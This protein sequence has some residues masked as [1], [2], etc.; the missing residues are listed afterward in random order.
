MDSTRKNHK[1]AF[2]NLSKIYSNPLFILTII[3]V[4]ITAYLLEV[5]MKIGVP[6]W[7]VFNYLNNALYFAGMGKGSVLYLPP[8]IP[9]LT[10]LFFKAGYVSLN[11]IFILDSI[12]FIIG[13]IGL[14]LLL[15]QRFNEIQSLTGSL[16]FI[17]FPVVLAWAVTGGIDIPGVSFSI[18]AIYLTVLGI[19][20]N[21]KYLYFVIPLTMLAFLTRYT[22]GLIILPVLFYSLINIREI[23]KIKKVVIGILLELIVLVSG[24]LYVY[25]HLGTI[26]SFYSLLANVLTSTSK[27]LGDVA[28]NPNNWYYLQS[29]PNY[30]SLSPFSGTYQQLL[31]PSTGFPSILAYLIIL[32]AS[33]GIIFYIYRIIDVKYKNKLNLQNKYTIVK[34]ILLTILIFGAI[35][36]FNSTEYLLSEIFLFGTCFLLYN[37]LKNP[38]TK[39]IDLDIM[40]FLWFGAYFIFQSNLGIKVDRYFITMAPAL[41]YFIILGLSEFIDKIKPKIKNKDLKSWGIYSIIALIFLSSA[42]VTYIG[43]TPKKTF[44]MD[45]GEASNWIKGHDP[46]YNNKIIYSDYPPAVSW[47]LKKGTMG[48]FPRFYKNPDDFSNALLNKNADYYID[49][50]SEPKLNIKGYQIIKNFGNVAVYKKT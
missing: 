3:T 15:N 29:I 23:Q 16:I 36:T 41:A 44:T 7:D 2:T 33:M 10:S 27:G 45:I 26:S 30:I 19:K 9:F 42:T 17:S 48:G 5:Q 22:A 46:D 35:F 20:K 1:S 13:V 32:A 37:L 4:G 12:L 11:A 21:P 6:Y 31:N 50:L 40:I 24:F 47:Y 18:W 38:D 14:Y 49:S 43:H 28:Y 34:I 25:M 8:V 39:N